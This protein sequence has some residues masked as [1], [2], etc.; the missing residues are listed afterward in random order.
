MNTGETNIVENKSV[1]YEYKND[2]KFVAYEYKQ[3]VAGKN[4]I[5]FLIDGY[6]NFGWT[7]D[8]NVS[9]RIAD[10]SNIQGLSSNVVL[11]LKRDRK[12]INK[13]ELTRL[14]RNFEFCVKE[15]EHLERSKTSEA[16]MYA[17]ITGVVGTVFMAGSVFAVTADP[18]NIILCVVLA[19]PAFAGWVA[20]YFV[21]RKTVAKRTARADALIEDKQDEIFE[22]CEKGNKLLH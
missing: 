6:R 12:L 19:I 3:V 4:R 18:P 2:D 20:P 11:Q 10:N 7:A 13:T 9:Q 1:A 8:E 21:F 17:L 15:I 16:T 5:S 22:I 14:Q